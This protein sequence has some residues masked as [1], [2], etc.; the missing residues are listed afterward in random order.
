MVMDLGIVSA[1][2]G[3]GGIASV[4]QTRA[5]RV[6][7]RY[8]ASGRRLERALGESL[9]ARHARPRPVLAVYDWTHRTPRAETQPGVCRLRASRR[10][11]GAPHAAEFRVTMAD[12]FPSA[13]ALARCCGAA[14]TMAEHIEATAREGRGDLATATGPV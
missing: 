2:G 3:L 6:R 1:C 10:L 14:E 12:Y 13:P 8:A 4:V 9:G 7:F 11:T 5:R